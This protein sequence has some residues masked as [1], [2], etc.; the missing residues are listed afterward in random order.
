MMKYLCIAVTLAMAFGII[1]VAIGSLGSVFAQ[2]NT[3]SNATGGNTTGATQNT[4]GN[5]SDTGTASGITNL[6]G[7]NTESLLNNTEV[8]D[9]TTGLQDLQKEQTTTDPNMTTTTK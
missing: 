7:T 4:T 5:Q 9:P 8:S 1:L 3:T 6:T 2:T